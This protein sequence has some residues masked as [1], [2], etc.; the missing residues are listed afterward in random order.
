MSGIGTDNYVA[1]VFED[2]QAAFIG[3][4][5]LW[6]LASRG[7]I[8]VYGAAV[9]RRDE[10]GHVQVATKASDAGHRTAVGVGILALLGA[11]TGPLGAVAAATIAVGATARIGTTAG[12]LTALTEGAASGDEPGA[13]EI[14]FTLERGQFA[15]V[16]ELSEEQAAPTDAAMAQLGG[17][18]FRRPKGTGPND[19]TAFDDYGASLLPYDYDPHFG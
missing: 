15:V 10:L 19:A 6:N 18:V 2:E 7:D 1:V 5:T 4:H 13:H 12:G 16:A 14:G 11:L 9:I 17:M 3:L 8:T